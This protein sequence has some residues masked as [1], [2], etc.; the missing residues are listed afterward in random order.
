METIAIGKNRRQLI[1]RR[2]EKIQ[3][4]FNKIFQNQDYLLVP[5]DYLKVTN[6]ALNKS[7][8]RMRPLLALLGY[9]AIQGD[10]REPQIIELAILIEWFHKTSLVLDD[11]LDEDDYRKGFPAVHKMFGKKQALMN[12]LI[13]LCRGYNHIIKKYESI[14]KKVVEILREGLDRCLVG[15]AR[16]IKWNS[17]TSNLDLYIRTISGKTAALSE[18]AM[19]ACCLLAKSNRPQTK[20]LSD[21]GFHIGMGYQ[22]LNDLKNFTGIENEL[23]KGKKKDIDL[24]RPN[25]LSALAVDQGWADINWQNKIQMRNFLVKS[26]YNIAEEHFQQCLQSLSATHNFFYKE[27]YD[28]LVFIISEVKNVW[29]LID[30]DITAI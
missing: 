26:S 28:C 29:S 25:I 4:E 1:E 10:W 14:D 15:Q 7:G 8:N 23:G 6:Y 17:K 24:N 12:G 22:I 19:Q 5:E 2:L 11:I 27:Y 16:D 3:F 9:A 20:A 13:M 30:R 18:L 21:Y